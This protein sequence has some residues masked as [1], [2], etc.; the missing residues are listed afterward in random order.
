MKTKKN[1]NVLN[2]FK[3]FEIKNTKDVLGGKKTCTWAG[4]MDGRPIC[5]IIDSSTGEESCN[6]PDSGVEVG[7]SWGA[8]ANVGSG[9]ATAVRR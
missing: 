7:D 5:D 9:S 1:A 2:A 4:S 8:I 6:V 3:A